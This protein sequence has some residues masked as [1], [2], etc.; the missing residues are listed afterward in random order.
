MNEPDDRY[1]A[2]RR[3]PPFPS[4]ATK[5]LRLLEDDNVSVKKP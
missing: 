1:R 3:L 4:I 2:L 5:L